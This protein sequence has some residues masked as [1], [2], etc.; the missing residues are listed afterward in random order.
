MI[1]LHTN[2]AKQINNKVPGKKLH[3][4]NKIHHHIGKDGKKHWQGCLDLWARHLYRLSKFH[5]FG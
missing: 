4:L 5:M 1:H 2:S 3:V